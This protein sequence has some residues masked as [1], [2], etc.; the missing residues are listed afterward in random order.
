VRVRVRGGLLAVIAGGVLVEVIGRWLDSPPL[1]L[2][3][4]V[5]TLLA[6][7]AY[8]LV[9]GRHS[10][11]FVRWPLLVAVAVV[12]V[13]AVNRLIRYDQIR[14]T[15]T[16]TGG[17]LLGVGPPD[18]ST[19]IAHRLFGGLRD[20]APAILLFGCLAVAVWFLPSR[21]RV[22]VGV[23]S[24]VA[25]A[26]LAA[27]SGWSLWDEARGGWYDGGGVTSVLIAL[28]YVAAPLLVVVL[29]LGTVVVGGQRAG[30][31]AL[32]AVGV[33]IMT[34]PALL[35]DGPARL[36]G[37]PLPPV[38]ASTDVAKG[39]LIAVGPGRPSMTSVLM[40]LLY[41]A[42]LAVVVVGCLS[43]V[44]TRPAEDPA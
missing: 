10:R 31:G 32:T 29:A 15:V 44:R 5:V 2:R 14:P 20:A 21:R 8:V 13:P 22:A 12:T 17:V 26:L 38:Y 43:A 37:V 3:A 35:F 1:Y 9:A 6:L 25:A 4:S 27:L 41:T 42:G 39:Y 11:P 18:M 36:A 30:R 16:Y 40:P 24:L 33:A 19:V 7:A 34:V 23:V 28:A